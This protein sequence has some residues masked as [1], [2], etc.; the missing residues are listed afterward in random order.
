[1]TDY[2]MAIWGLVAAAGLL[3]SAVLYVLLQ[4][5]DLPVIKRQS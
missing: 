3:T 1:M 5:T 4:P 2:S